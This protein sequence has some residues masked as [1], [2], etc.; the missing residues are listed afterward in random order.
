[1]SDRR[2]SAVIRAYNEAKHIG[3]LLDGL[4]Q[5]TV[6]PDEIILVDS[7]ST[8]DTVTIAEAA[9]CIIV[10]IAKDEFSFGRAL[11]RG[12]AVAN[13]DVLLIASAHVYPV[14]NTYVEHMAKSAR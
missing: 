12:C 1:M 2:V 5:Q 6:R 14:Y 7:G 10:P 4:E 8:D 13:G 11:N 3:R 9:G